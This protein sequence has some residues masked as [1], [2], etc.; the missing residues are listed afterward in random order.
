MPTVRP[1]AAS[2]CSKNDPARAQLPRTLLAGR[3][4]AQPP[5]QNQ[6]VVV[7]ARDT[8]VE[9]ARAHQARN[10]AP[11]GARTK[12]RVARPPPLRTQDV[13]RRF[14]DLIVLVVEAQHVADFVRE[15]MRRAIQAVGHQVRR[16]RAG[17]REFDGKVRILGR[18]HDFERERDGRSVEVC[19]RGV[20]GPDLGRAGQFS[21]HV[22]EVS[23][24]FRKLARVVH[25]HA[26]D[27]VP[28]I[29]RV[30]IV[31]IGQRDETHVRERTFDVRSATTGKCNAR[32][33]QA[34]VPAVSL[35]VVS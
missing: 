8:R 29:V 20:L 16:T 21:G 31:A 7:R 9:P 22:P 25:S 32:L 30:E 5:A 12:P 10:V 3:I 27:C 1:A 18:G 23:R 24:L 17:R 19:S 6:I 14:A 2:S 34:T 13:T 26:D 11:K 33:R 4:A 35:D 28:S 15:K